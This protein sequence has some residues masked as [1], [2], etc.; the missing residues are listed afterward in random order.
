MGTILIDQRKAEAAAHGGA[1][2]GGGG[3]GSL[4]EGLERASLA[5]R[6]GRIELKSLDEL[7]DEELVV[8]ASAVGAPAA[9]D[10]CVRPVDHIKS[11]DLLVE[12]FPGKIAG[13]ISNENGG[14]SGVNGWLQAAVRGLP[15]IAAPANGRAQCALPRSRPAGWWLS[16]VIRFR[17]PTCGN[18]PHRGA[19]H[20]PSKS[21]RR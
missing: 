6:L 17:P 9:K 2:L 12:Q 21:A 15:M 7:D 18:T 11:V 3:G 19:L 1:V 10:Q 16:A 20:L 4:K 14:S 8:T 5:V 13:I